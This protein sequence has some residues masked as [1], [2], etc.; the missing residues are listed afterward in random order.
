MT[1]TIDLYRWTGSPPC[2]AVM[3]VAQMLA[4]ELN[5]IEV[6]ILTEEQMK[7]EF[8]KVSVTRL[9]EVKNVS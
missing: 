1:R 4:I 3:L 2:Q 8:I 6:D 5:L 7:P 9:I